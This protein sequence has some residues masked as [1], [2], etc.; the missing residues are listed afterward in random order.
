MARL[1]FTLQCV[2][3]VMANSLSLFLPDPGAP[4]SVY[5]AGAS[6]LVPGVFTWLTLI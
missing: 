4:V 3:A 2:T 6:I 5:N 1:V